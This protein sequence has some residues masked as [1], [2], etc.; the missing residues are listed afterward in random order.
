MPNII[1]ELDKEQHDALAAALPTT[2]ISPMATPS[3]SG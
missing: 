2:P 1:A 3:K